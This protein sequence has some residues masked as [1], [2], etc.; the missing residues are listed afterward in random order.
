MATGGSFTDV[1]HELRPEGRDTSMH[2]HGREFY[3]MLG[4]S[5]GQG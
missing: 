3:F 1:R 4:A 2:G 5:S